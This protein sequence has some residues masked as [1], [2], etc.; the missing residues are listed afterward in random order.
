MVHV[1]ASVQKGD[2]GA[3]RGIEQDRRRG[4]LRLYPARKGAQAVGPNE[5]HPILASRCV[6]N[7]DASKDGWVL[8]HVFR[9]PRRNP[10]Q[11][12]S[13]GGSSSGR[14]AAAGQ[15]RWKS[16][17]ASRSNARSSKDAIRTE[18]VCAAW[19]A[20]Q[21]SKQTLLGQHTSPHPPFL[22][23]ALCSKR[24]DPSICHGTATRRAKRSD[25]LS[26]VIAR[27]KHFVNAISHASESLVPKRAC[28][29]S[30][31]WSLPRGPN[32]EATHRAVDLARRKVAERARR[33]RVAEIRRT[34][35]AA[36]TTHE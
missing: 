36:P 20:R 19:S 17:D 23:A 31:R 2:L 12:A 25:L 29:E 1:R 18:G 33:E 4:G 24:R 11:P 30:S 7:L 6:P 3:A 9:R 14:A 5:S 16:F 27:T 22:S 13:R 28:G 26:R 15:E 34:A 10:P 21:R 8:A 32:G 35:G